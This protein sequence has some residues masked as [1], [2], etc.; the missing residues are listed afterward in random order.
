MRNI[1]KLKGIKTRKQALDFAL[2]VI[3]RRAR[4]DLL[5]REKPPK[6]KG[7]WIRKGYDISALRELD[8]PT[9]RRKIG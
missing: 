2:S 3:E 9:Y 5:L 6:V 8:K 7:D 1:M 4:L